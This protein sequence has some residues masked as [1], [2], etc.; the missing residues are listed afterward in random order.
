MLETVKYRFSLEKRVKLVP[1]KSIKFRNRAT[2][3]Y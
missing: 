3:V 2:V 1:V